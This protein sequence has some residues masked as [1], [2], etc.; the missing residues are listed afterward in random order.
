MLKQDRV[1]KEAVVIVDK[2]QMRW[3][4]QFT[5]AKLPKEEISKR[6]ITPKE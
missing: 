5:R 4:C 1:N 3:T 6:N 2:R